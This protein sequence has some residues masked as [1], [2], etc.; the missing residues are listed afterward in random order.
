MVKFTQ[1]QGPC[2]TT[3]PTYFSCP[4]C[5]KQLTLL[6]INPVLCNY[7][8]RKLKIKYIDLRESLKY[9]VQYHFN[10]ILPF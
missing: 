5:N 10:Y 6:H 8:S 1:K 4:H 9:R 2:I 3:F 7:C